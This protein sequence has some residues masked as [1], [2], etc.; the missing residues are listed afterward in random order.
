MKLDNLTKTETGNY[1]MEV[2]I[3]DV[4]VNSYGYYEFVVQPVDKSITDDGYVMSLRNTTKQ[5]NDFVET[6]QSVAEADETTMRLFGC[7]YRELP[8]KFD[9]IIDT[10]VVGYYNESSNLIYFVDRKASMYKSYKPL[11]K[12]LAGT[13]EYK[14]TDVYDNGVQFVVE[15]D[16]DGQLYGK[17]FIYMYESWC[18]KTNV[19]KYRTPHATTRVKAYKNMLRLFGTINP[20][21]TED[22]KVTVKYGTYNTVYL[23]LINTTGF[24]AEF[25][26]YNAFLDGLDGAPTDVQIEEFAKSTLE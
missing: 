19:L 6:E 10:Q 16:V 12:E 23:D 7:S 18:K 5:G 8:D 2:N 21:V 15:I 9:D 11:K 26:K 20:K 13:K 22:S 4:E 1:E 14:I 17:K 24:D 3:L 25:E